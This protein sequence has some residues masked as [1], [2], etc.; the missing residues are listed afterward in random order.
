MEVVWPGNYMMLRH[1]DA[2]ERTFPEI[3]QMRQKFPSSEPTAFWIRVVDM[4][5]TALREQG[6][7]DEN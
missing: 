7:A 6:V 5:R 1:A 2:M 4:N 3:R